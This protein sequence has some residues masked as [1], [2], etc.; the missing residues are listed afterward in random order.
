LDFALSASIGVHRRLKTL[1]LWRMHGEP[2]PPV[3]AL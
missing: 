2:L 1:R 3:A